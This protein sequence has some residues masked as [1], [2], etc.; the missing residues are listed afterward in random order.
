M[1]HALAKASF[2][3]KPGNGGSI[4]PQLFPEDFYGDEPMRAVFGPK[5][6]RRSPLSD[7]TLEGIARNGLAD[8]IFT[9]HGAN[10]TVV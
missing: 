2:A 1:R 9:W 3:K 5:H 8:Q 6:S 10:L 7:F 4:G